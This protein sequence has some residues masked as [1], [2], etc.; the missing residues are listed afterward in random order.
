MGTIH[1]ILGCFLLLQSG[2]FGLFRNTHNKDIFQVEYLDEVSQPQSDEK[3]KTPY[4]VNE[5][6]T[7]WAVLVAGSNGY[8][9]YRHQVQPQS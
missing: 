7:I 5:N 6:G 8:Y 3:T 9:N 4:K 2:A 1:G